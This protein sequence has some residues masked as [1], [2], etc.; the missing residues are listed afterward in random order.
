MYGVYCLVSEANPKRIYVGM[1]NNLK[2]RLRQHN[3]EIT[4]GARSTS[5]KLHRPWQVA[6]YVHGLTRTEAAQ[7]EWAIK[8]HRIKGASGVEGFQRKLTAL[9][10]RDRWTLRAPLVSEVLGRIKFEKF[11]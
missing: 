1:T 9:M 8:H 11:L 2:R 10:Q 3:G 4:G 7:L 5:S 6:F